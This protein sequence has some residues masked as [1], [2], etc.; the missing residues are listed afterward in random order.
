[1]KK[2]TKI[3]TR[4]KPGID[5]PKIDIFG[6]KML[7]VK[8]D[9]AL[10]IVDRKI[11]IKD[12]TTVFF[13][14]ADCLNKVFVDKE[15][16]RIL[17]GNDITFAD[18]SG[19]SLAGR[20]LKTPVADNVNGTDLLP[21]I[22]ELASQKGYG[23]FLLGAAPGVA[24]A[25]KDKLETRY[26]GL[27]INGT[28]DGFFDKVNS[29]AEVVNQINASGSD[30]LLVAFGAPLQEK[31]IVDNYIQI[32]VSILMGVGGLFDFYSGR[33]ARAPVW[34]RRI[35]LEWTFRLLQEPKRMW[36]RYILGNPLFLYRVLRWKI[37]RSAL[38]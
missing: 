6:V 18:G 33:I 27:R 10:Q 31:F 2:E 37:G 26:P 21:R 24:E 8:M 14:N 35:G 13:V 11:E 28:K 25:M 12:K 23:I 32:D 29:A 34:L 9:E 3:V 38:I 1:M 19:I 7:N 36:K 30:I 16:Y 5:Y 4:S 15:Y 22:C 17:R 20:M